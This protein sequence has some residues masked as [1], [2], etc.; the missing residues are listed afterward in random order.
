MKHEKARKQRATQSALVSESRLSTAA[1]GAQWEPPREASLS[2]PE[3]QDVLW[4]HAR[5][6]DV[7]VED[8]GGGGGARAIDRDATRQL[9]RGRRD[10]RA[11][12]RDD[13]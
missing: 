10:H 7:S 13:Q 5:H 12:I 6:A 11:Q 9:A 4:R 2:V 3:L 1:R 8:P